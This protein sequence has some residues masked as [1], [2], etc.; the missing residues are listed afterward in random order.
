MLLQLYTIKAIEINEISGFV[1]IIS[2]L[3]GMIWN[4]E[5]DSVEGL[6]EKE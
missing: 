4:T 1:F 5:I 6:K 2:L 3:Y